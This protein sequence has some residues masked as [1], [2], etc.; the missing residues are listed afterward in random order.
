MHFLKIQ[1]QQTSSGGNA[2]TF[3][4]LLLVTLA[5]H[6]LHYRVLPI[7]NSRTKVLDGYY[8]GGYNKYIFYF[9]VLLNKEHCVRDTSSD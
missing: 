2:G 1:L 3:S 9:S 7:L 6:K 4:P 8:L 5:F